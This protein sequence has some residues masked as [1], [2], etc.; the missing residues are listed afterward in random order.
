MRTCKKNFE[1][2]TYLIDK[3]NKHEKLKGRI[4][5]FNKLCNIKNSMYGISPINFLFIAARFK[6]KL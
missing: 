4:N 1:L 2:S 5:M 3:R 6:N